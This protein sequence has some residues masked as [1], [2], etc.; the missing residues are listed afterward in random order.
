MTIVLCLVGFELR[1]CHVILYCLWRCRL[2]ILIIVTYCSVDIAL[3]LLEVVAIVGVNGKQIVLLLLRTVV[4]IVSAIKVVG[5]RIIGYA[6][7]S[8][9]FCHVGAYC[10]MQLYIWKEV[11]LVVNIKVAYKSLH[12]AASIIHVD[13]STWVA[14]SG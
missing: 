10:C 3:C 11:E 6:C 12:I 8:L 9:A 4:V 7:V 5:C 2:P 14:L 13:K 1:A